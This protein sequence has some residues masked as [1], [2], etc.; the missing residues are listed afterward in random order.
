MIPAIRTWHYDHNNGGLLRISIIDDG[1]VN[2]MI[3][4]SLRGVSAIFRER[5][6]RENSRLTLRIWY[7]T[8]VVESIMSMTHISRLRYHLKYLITPSLSLCL[9]CR[10]QCGKR[11]Y[12]HFPADATETSDAEINSSPEK[13]RPCSPRSL[14]CRRLHHH[15]LLLSPPSLLPSRT[16]TSLRLPLSMVR[17]PFLRLR[18][19]HNLHLSRTTHDAPQST[20]LR[21]HFYCLPYPL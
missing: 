9:L 6:Y 17:L 3:A 11:N 14:S 10:L 12:L 8:L 5:R 18:R 19:Q 16:H 7:A 21:R 4:V 2:L 15:R 13:G 20:P 1:A